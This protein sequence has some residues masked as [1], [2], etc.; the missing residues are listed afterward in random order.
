MRKLNGS[1]GRF[2]IWVDTWI[3]ICGNVAI[4]EHHRLKARLVPIQQTLPSLQYLHPAR[5]LDMDG[6]YDLGRSQLQCCSCGKTFAQQNAFSNHM[7]F[8]KKNT[9]Q[10]QTALT[11]IRKVWA[12]G[13]SGSKWFK[14]MHP[15]SS[16]LPGM[17]DQDQGALLIAQHHSRLAFNRIYLN[18]WPASLHSSRVRQ[19]KQ[20]QLQFPVHC[21]LQNCHFWQLR[22]QEQPCTSLI[23][24]TI[25]FRSSEM[26]P[27]IIR[28]SFYLKNGFGGKERK[29]HLR[30]STL[31][32]KSSKIQIF[33]RKT[34]KTPNSA[35]STKSL[36]IL[37]AMGHPGWVTWMLDGRKNLFPWRFPFTGSMQI[38]GT[39]YLKWELFIVGALCW[40]SGSGLQMLMVNTSIMSLTNFI[41]SHVW[42]IHP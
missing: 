28:V 29:S 24:H 12:E 11:G 10:L 36:G 6:D 13:E 3:P 27:T 2:P 34:S 15:A 30:T 19:Q 9:S 18:L 22:V 41:G 38:Q 14:L 25:N 4:C 39:R 21:C 40:S 31:S 42:R 16:H 5:T 7:C 1:L 33:L 37:M 20:I 26:H 8:C 35:S 17:G 23:H 32:Y